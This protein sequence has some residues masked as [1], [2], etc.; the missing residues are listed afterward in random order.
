MNGGPDVQ[1]ALNQ[2]MQ[3]GNSSNPLGG[4]SM[5]AAGSLL[6]GSANYGN[7]TNILNN[8]YGQTQNAL[9]PFASGNAM[10]PASNPAL[11][12]ELANVGTQVQNTVAPQFAAAGRFASPA[13][14]QAEA[15]GI[16]QGST[17]ILQ[18]AAA[19]QLGA[20]NA[21]Q[22]AAG[23]TA[24]GLLGA[25]AANAG[26]LGSGIGAAGTAYGNQTLGPQLA[27]QAAL[28]GNQLPIQNAGALAGILGPIAGMF[29]QQNGTGSSTSQTSMPWWAP[30]GAI[31]QFMGAFKGK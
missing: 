5:N 23:N 7:A 30:L 12:Q 18:N 3:I 24:G 10:D 19:N 29:G 8:A 21:L 20:I 25:D 15:R 6:N 31:G 4:A 13:M 14:A 11:A 2:L 16:T 26:I 1:N 27:L 9:S 28:T 17:G 22:G